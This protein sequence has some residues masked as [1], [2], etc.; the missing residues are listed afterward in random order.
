[1]DEYMPENLVV[2]GDNSR[3]DGGGGQGGGH[4]NGMDPA[5]EVWQHYPWVGVCN[6]VAKLPEEYNGKTLVML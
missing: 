5:V 3:I 2:G 6:H 1:M 4:R